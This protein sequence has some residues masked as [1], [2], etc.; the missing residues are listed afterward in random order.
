MYPQFPDK[1][2]LTYPEFAPDTPP[3]IV[4]ADV[5]YGVRTLRPEFSMRLLPDD[6]PWL[7]RWWHWLKSRVFRLRVVD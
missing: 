3:Q 5:L 1:P 2:D 4:R 7:V 6:R